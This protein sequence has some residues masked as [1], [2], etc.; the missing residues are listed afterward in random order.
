MQPSPKIQLTSL[1]QMLLH[2]AYWKNIK[3]WLGLH[4]VEPREWHVAQIVKEWQ[5]IF[6]LKIGPMWMT[7]LWSLQAMQLSPR[8]RLTSLHQMRFHNAYLD[9]SE[10]VAWST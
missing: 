4:D 6:V 1:P 10:G 8:I 7:K 3:E 2:G 9:K 5:N